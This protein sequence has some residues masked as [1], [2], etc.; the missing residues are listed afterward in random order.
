MHR[1]SIRFFFAS[2]LALSLVACG[3]DMG[4]GDDAGADAGTGM[5]A[6]SGMDAGRADGSTGTDGSTGDDAGPVDDAGDLDAGDLDA[7]ITGCADDSACASGTEYCAKPRCDAP[8]G[9]C[10]ALPTG[11][12]DV[13]D[14]V[15]GCDGVTYG[16][17]CEAGA[18][19]QNIAMVGACP[20]TTDA[21]IPDAGPSGCTS[22]ADCAGTDYCQLPLAACS[23][24]G[25]CN[26]RPT[27]CPDVINPVCGCDGSTYDN[28]CEA[29]ATGNN[30]ASRGACGT[31]TCTT[32]PPRG[33]CYEDADCTSSVVGRPQRCEG[34]VC[35]SAAGV[36]VPTSLAPGRCWADMDCAPGETCMGAIICPCGALCIR[37]DAPG[38]CG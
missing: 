28:A 22:N 15:C 33:C 1:R 23:G 11:C 10:V 31:M 8:L 30:V 29:A 9:G 38:R 25:R 3:D 20:T 7:G 26:V 12:P 5:D 16:N 4:P 21:G 27:I 18:A 17:P 14:P 19:G 37:A 13:V 36:C 35:P 24:V 32:P 34:G 6:S 2:V